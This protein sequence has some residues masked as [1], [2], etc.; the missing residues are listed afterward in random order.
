MI[1]WG[2]PTWSTSIFAICVPEDRRPLGVKLIH[3]VRGVGYAFRDRRDDQ[4]KRDACA[5]SR[6]RSAVRGYDAALG[7]CW[8]CICLI[9]RSVRLGLRIFR[10]G[11]SWANRL[12]NWA[13]ADAWSGRNGR[14]RGTASRIPISLLGYARESNT[15]SSCRRITKPPSLSAAALGAFWKD[16]FC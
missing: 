2:R 13:S 7:T 15:S 11:R 9:V 12:G 8:A 3:T 10:K 16:S 14:D 1:S 4:R 5:P 6:A